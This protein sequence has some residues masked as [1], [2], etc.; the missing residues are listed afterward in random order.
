MLGDVSHCLCLALGNLF[1]ATSDPSIVLPL[2]GLAAQW[3]DQA[4]LQGWLF[5]ALGSGGRSANI[6][7]HS[8]IHLC[9]PPPAGLYAC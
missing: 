6:P 8:G 5:S 4:A 9:L 7:R 2:V 1:E 3:K